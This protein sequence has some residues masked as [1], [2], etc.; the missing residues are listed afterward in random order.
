MFRI[1]LDT[2]QFDEDA[3][4]PNMHIDVTSK[5]ETAVSARVR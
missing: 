2:A 1:E 3:L 4:V 5:F